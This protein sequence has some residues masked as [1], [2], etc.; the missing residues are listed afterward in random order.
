M[1]SAVITA[2][3]PLSSSTG[4]LRVAIVGL[5]PKGMFALER[6][7]DHGS[8]LGGNAQIAVDLFEPH[9]TPGAGPNYDPDQPTFLRMNFEASQIDMWWSSHGA[10]PRRER[11]SF[12]AWRDSFEPDAGADTFPP[13]AQVGR[14]LAHGLATL[15]RHSPASIA[16]RLRQALVADLR[17]SR[18]GW[19]VIADGE[20]AVY[21]EVLIATGHQH[22]ED[23]G[24]RDTCT[25]GAAFAPRVFPVERWLSRARVEP[26]STVAIRGFALTFID[27][28]LALT[29]GR[30][31]TFE[32]ADHTDRLRY[33]SG[34]GSP[35]LIIPF[36]RTGRPMLAKP[37]SALAAGIP[38]LATIAEEGRLRISELEPSVDLRDDLIPLLARIV[39]ASLRAANGGALDDETPGAWLTEAAAG[40]RTATALGPVEE[41]ERS[42]AVGAGQ[43]TP[44]LS[45][46]L[47][48]AWRQLYPAL[49]A[50]LGD[51]GLRAA[52]WPAFRRLAV[53]MERVAFGPSALNAAKLVAL[54]DAGCVDLGASAGGRL[55]RVGARTL[56]R[57][58]HCE[59][60]VDVVID[61]VLPGPGVLPQDRLLMRLVADGHARIAPGRRGLDVDRACSCR[62]PDG[63]PTP[64]LSAVGRPTE[65]SVIGNDT[66]SRA[67]HPGIDE[68]ARRVA[69][70]ARAG[71]ELWMTDRV[72]QGA[73]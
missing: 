42:L 2:S 41:L 55:I 61:A 10:V 26:N 70:R 51:D 39:R 13:R 36:A 15:L 68:W 29:E 3:A 72:P 19:D 69:R 38:A 62:G 11:R 7:L 18:T 47:G 21:D 6:L 52:D 9:D 4:P 43:V 20:S 50:R 54:I 57:S 32:R 16:I 27:A 37:S 56:L 12:L 33:T 35:R 40:V 60:P 44:D 64:G 58:N 48:H 17:P 24:L 45:W 8:R 49:V 1:E 65:D 5:G 59:R 46:A 53:E 22:G 25:D 31:G 71:A 34:E 28:T 23:A 14:Y 73:S 67:L 63:A 66:L 30:G